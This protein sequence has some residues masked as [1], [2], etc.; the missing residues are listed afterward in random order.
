MSTL[1][2]ATTTEKPMES[3]MTSIELGRA[4][5]GLRAMS[6]LPS[7]RRISW[8]LF[9]GRLTAVGAAVALLFAASPARAG[10]GSSPQA[11]ASAIA[12][13][14]ADAI[15]SEL[16]RSEYL[17]CAACVD[18][19]TPLIDNQDQGIREVA[20]WWLVRRGVSRQIFT[21]MLNRLGQPDSVKARNAAD[22]L[23]SFGYANAV[24]PLGAALSNPLFTGEARAAMARALGTLKRSTAAAPLQAVLTDADPLVR[25]ASLSA[26][27]KVEGFSDGTVA[28]PLLGDADEN[29]RVQA[30][31]TV[32]QFHTRAAAS[33]LVQILQSDPSAS[34][35]KR[36]AWALGQMNAPASVAA[37]ALT[38]AST[39][40]ASPFVRSLAR[41]ALASLGQ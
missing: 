39:S 41:A 2:N 36:A 27:R 20:G 8:G 4:I 21:D 9:A 13:G 18:Y 10:H 35:R 37:P 7:H 15:K 40:D 19:V 26:L 34:V 29:V 6:K 14:S 30:I 38:A 23:G 24:A 28:M 5:G 33:N 11:V 32:A 3:S 25:A 16:E 31:F 22:I 17:V 12:S 1:A